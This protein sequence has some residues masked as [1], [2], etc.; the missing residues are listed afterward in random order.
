LKRT[1][2]HLV[3]P[4]CGKEIVNACDELILAA[5][6]KY[7]ALN[8]GQLLKETKVSKGSLSTHLN[9]LIASGKVEPSLIGRKVTYFLQEAS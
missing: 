8:W 5:F 1:P 3:C 9:G 4:Y 2:K 6:R 7:S